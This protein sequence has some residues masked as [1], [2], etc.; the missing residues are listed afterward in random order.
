MLRKAL[1]TATAIA[2]MGVGST[3][4]AMHGSGSS[5]VGGFG[6]AGIA[7]AHGG[8]AAFAPRATT[9]MV[10]GRVHGWA[11]NSFGRNTFA[12]GHGHDHF[13]HRGFE[14]GFGGPYYD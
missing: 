4:M 5:H 10:G 3:A 9:P 7:A 6:G 2:A 12:W 14:Y 13:H 11:G 8:G 1:I